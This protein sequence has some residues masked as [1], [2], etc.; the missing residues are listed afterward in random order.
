M[1]LADILD[2][3]RA[4]SKTEREKGDYFETL[5]RLF[6]KNDSTQTQ[7]Y[8]DVW[9]FADWAK[10]HG[11][12]GNDTGID[13]VAELADGTGF[14]A[15]QCKFYAPDHAIQKPDIDSFISAAA[16][17]AFARLVI[18]DTTHRDFGK[19]A[20]DTLNRLSKDWNRIRIS[21]L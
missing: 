8:S 15:I 7:Y 5:V 9:T 3:F 14:A 19:N 12:K 1:K 13:L 18:V 2:G 10:T 21:D 20:N 4:A 17:D 16:N 11:W 6:L